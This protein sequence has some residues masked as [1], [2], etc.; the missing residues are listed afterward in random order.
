VGL[1][2][3][4]VSTVSERIFREHGIVVRPF[5]QPG[6]NSLRVSPNLMNTE[7]EMSRLFSILERA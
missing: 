1:N 2:G 7:E 3:G 5:P 4:E 6:L